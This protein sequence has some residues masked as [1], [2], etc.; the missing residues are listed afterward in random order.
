MIVYLGI[1]S[2]IQ[3]TQNINQAKAALAECYSSIRFSRTFE[4]ESIGFRGDNFFNLV[5]E[6]DTN[7]TLEQL[8][9]YLK[10]LEN[11]LGRVRGSQKFASRSIDIDILLFGEKVCKQPVELPR[12]EI[13]ENAYVLWPL[14]ELAP[15]LIEPGGFESYAQLWQAFDHSLQKIHPLDE[16]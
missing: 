6:I 16:S 5:A 12:G 4:S 14:A 15:E 7:E 9:E 11:Q 8:L 13:R 10:N 3:P 2:N 1:G